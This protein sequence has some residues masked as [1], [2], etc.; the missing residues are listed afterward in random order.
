M[1]LDVN[2]CIET[3][4][5]QLFVTSLSQSLSVYGPKYN[6]PWLDTCIFVLFCEKGLSTRL[7][8]PESV[9]ADAGRGRGTLSLT[10]IPSAELTAGYQSLNWE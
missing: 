6:R 4:R 2:S 3:Y 9:D 1:S 8:G 7:Q 10:S 5:T